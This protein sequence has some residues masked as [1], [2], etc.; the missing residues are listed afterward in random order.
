MAINYWSPDGSGLITTTSTTS[1]PVVGCGGGGG[2][3]PVANPGLTSGMIVAP[4]WTTQT[5]PFFMPDTGVV[6]PFTPV[7]NRLRADQLT[8]L[9]EHEFIPMDGT[10]MCLLCYALEEYRDVNDHVFV[11]REE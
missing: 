4:T 6:S 10:G 8:L 9:M 1:Y 7:R 5:V 2:Y 11:I 3:P